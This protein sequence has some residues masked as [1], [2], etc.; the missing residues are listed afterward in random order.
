MAPKYVTKPGPWYFD[1]PIIGN[2]FSKIGRAIDLYATPCSPTAEIWVYGFFQAIPTLVA[3]L[4]KPELIDLKI[5]HRGRRQR[6]GKRMKFIGGLIFRDAVLEVP[7]PRWVV[8][9]IYALGQRIGWWFLVADA[10]EDF[11]INWMSMAYEWQG[12]TPGPVPPY[13]NVKGSTNVATSTGPGWHNFV[14]FTSFDFHQ[15]DKAAAPPS[16]EVLATC[17]PRHSLTATTKIHGLSPNA[18]IAAWQIMRTG[19]SV[20]EA[21][22]EPIKQDNG[23]WRASFAS[24]PVAQANTGQ[25]FYTRFYLE[26]GDEIGVQ[27]Y[28]WQM[29][30]A[31]GLER[32]PILPDP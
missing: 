9:R 25:D 15:S 22:A 12:C 11:S 27:N 8:F 2:D 5:A 17:L 16:M 24:T 6:K 20:P 10:L 21:E 23:E 32:P 3:T 26:G 4:V 14:H 29:T 1:I 30:S 19:S 13:W 28:E 7:V 31:F 18:R